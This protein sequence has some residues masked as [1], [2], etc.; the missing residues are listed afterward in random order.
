MS[1]ILSL[2]GL[3]RYSLVREFPPLDPGNDRGR[4]CFQLCNPSTADATI[5]DP[6]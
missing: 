3:Y 1:A 2:D 4:V 5:N 6:T